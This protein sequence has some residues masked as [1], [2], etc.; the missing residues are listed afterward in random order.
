[1]S[2]VVSVAD[3]DLAQQEVQQRMMKQRRMVVWPRQQVWRWGCWRIWLS[4][5]QVVVVLGLELAG[6]HYCC[7]FRL[8]CERDKENCFL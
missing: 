7:P 3:L 6:R 4:R 8:C 2:P 1:M 5:E